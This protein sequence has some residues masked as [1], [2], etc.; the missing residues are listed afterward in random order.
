M[1]RRVRLRIFN[2]RRR[3][4]MKYGFFIKKL[5]LLGKK[6]TSQ[7]TLNNGLNVIY[8]PTDTGKSYIFQCINYM[9]GA[10]D[11]PDEIEQSAE[12]ELIRMEIETYSNK[13]YTLERKIS[14]GSFK[15]YECKMSQISDDTP[16]DTLG[17]TSA[18]KNSLSKF[19]LSICGFSQRDYKVKKNQDNKL[20]N[21]SY[22]GIN[23]FVMV[24]EVKIIQKQS[25][26]FS[27]NN[28]SK[29]QEKSIFK[30]LL[31]N[32]DDSNLLEKPSNIN[33]INS[34]IKIAL[35]ENL[36]SEAKEKL[37]ILEKDKPSQEW[38]TKEIKLLT[39]NKN[40]VKEKIDTLTNIRKN[41]WE[42]LQIY[43]SKILSIKELTK[44]FHLLEEQYKSDLERLIFFSE[45]KHYFNQL[46]WERCPLCHKVLD[47]SGDQIIHE[48]HFPHEEI[49][50][51]AISIEI[52]KIRNHM[53]DLESTIFNMTEEQNSLEST[54]DTLVKKYEQISKEIDD[55]LQ[56]TFKKITNDLHRI[57]ETQR[58]INE[59]DFLNRNLIHLKTEKDK[60]S[61]NATNNTKSTADIE[62]IS[63]YSIDFC[64]EIEGILKSWKFPISDNVKLDDNSYDI[65]ISGKHRKLFGKGYRAITY[66]AFIL[67]LMEYCIKKELPHTGM[68]ILDSPLTT[69]K[70]EDS[71]VGEEDKVPEEIQNN[72]YNNLSKVKQQVII[73][74]NKKPSQ[75][76]IKKINFIEFTRNENSG[77]YG[78]IEV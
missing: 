46:H 31:T 23:H 26:I 60:I 34:K 8:G 56:P 30:L 14:G 65:V 38:L 7:I 72:F 10:K 2:Q 64:K 32:K 54:K 11:S 52:N 68:I 9:L 17:S 1:G 5:A 39:S 76:V 58:K 33:N 16:S 62:Y 21:F 51:Q 19:L 50:A 57:L 63:N 3:K 40:G 24:D 74:E 36:I 22:R 43:N 29:T 37:K 75:E 59:L 41:T 47:S 66:S 6:G 71:E 42:N 77:R 25:P 28:T 18:S 35:L 45:G 78:F 12:Y 69:Y 48:E 44:R 55:E 13:T 70:E 15:R 27:G 20:V 73:F 53:R 67:G 4:R 49:K 61:S